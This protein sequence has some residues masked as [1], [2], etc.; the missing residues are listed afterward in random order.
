[1]TLAPNFPAEPS[2]SARSHTPKSGFASSRGT[3]E[4]ATVTTADTRLTRETLL[5]G[6]SREA[7]MQPAPAEPTANSA[8]CVTSSAAI[9]ASSTRMKTRPISEPVTSP[10]SSRVTPATSSATNRARC[11]TSPQRMARD[12][13]RHTR[14]GVRRRDTQG[15]RIELHRRHYRDTDRLPAHGRPA[16]RLTWKRSS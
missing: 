6:W 4:T 8:T 7:D 15:R 1:M 14:P 16:R 9:S 11:L 3:G 5:P 2:S 12:V 10:A 13:C